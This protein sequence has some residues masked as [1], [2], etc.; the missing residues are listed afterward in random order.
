MLVFD[1]FFGGLG[2][3]QI[4]VREQVWQNFRQTIE[5]LHARHADLMI[6]LESFSPKPAEPLDMGEH[7]IRS[8]RHPLP[9]VQPRRQAEQRG[10]RADP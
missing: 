5:M 6:G 9:Q 8:S 7:P 1:G 3:H 2:G 4:Y 10:L